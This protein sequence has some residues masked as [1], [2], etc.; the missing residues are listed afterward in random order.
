M[1]PM[2][3]ALIILLITIVVFI[4]EPI[5]VVIT[6]IAASLAYAFTNLIEQEDIFAGYNSDIIILLAAMMVVGSAL[7]HTGV[8]RVIGDQMMR[9][10]GKSERNIVLMTLV[11]STLLSGV[12]SNI[13]VMVAMAPLVTAMTMSIGVGPSKALF[14]L[15]FGAQ[16]GG[17]LTLIGV[18]SNAAAASVMADLGYEP[19]GFFG[20]TPFGIGIAVI[21]ILYFM[22]VAMR[23][24]PD[25][26]Y[27]PQFA[28]GESKTL[29][30]GKAAVAVT[31]LLG[32]LVGIAANPDWLPMHVVAVIGALVIIASRCMSVQ[33]AIR[34]IDWV[35]LLL[36]GALSAIS[37]GLSNS[38]AAEWMADLILKVLGDDP[39]TFM[40]TT[41]IFFTTAI[42][43]QFM[44]NI[45]TIL[46]FLPIGVSV[47]E[48][49]GVSPYPVA[50]IIT[51]AGAASYATP[52]AAPQNMM[53]VGWTQYKFMDFVKVGAPMIVLTYL[54]ILP[55]IPI[56]L[57]Y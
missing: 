30:K 37:V 39:N 34:A 7:F 43:T 1:T 19:F 14:A 51:L 55:L 26:E 23:F 31:T 22:F 47:A 18:G 48:S 3:I 38:G 12:T 40:I 9:I 57:P 27:I 11:V 46:V 8:T 52:F 29:H 21:G 28:K 32:V 54:I 45:P 41:V 4:W 17:F 20:I 15:L 2:I 50:M 24:L 6:A 33:D 25:T 42:L 5:P 13:G 56:F 16:F 53:T 49:I 36:V 44:S 35:T 10:T